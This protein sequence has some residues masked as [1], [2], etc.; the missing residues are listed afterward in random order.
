MIAI[1][2]NSLAGGGAEKVVLTLVKEIGASGID[3]QLILVEREQF[4][5]LPPNVK[6]HYLTDYENIGGS[7]NKFLSVFS[8]ARLLKKL[9]ETHQIEVVQSHLIRSNYINVL[10]QVMGSPHKS[11]IVNHMLVSF[12]KKRGLLGKGNLRLY[13]MLYHKADMI[14]SISKVMK[15]DLDEFFALPNTHPHQVIYNPHDIDTINKLAQ[16]TPEE[17]TFDPNKKYIISVGRL[18]ARKRVDVL[19]QAFAELRHE[20]PE[21][22]LLILGNGSE[23]ASYQSSAETLGVASS[24][25][26]MGHIQNPFAYLSRSDVF[27]L[28]SEDEGL[29]NI[30]IE[31][32]I[33]G[34]AVISSDCVS[35]PRE[36]L[37]PNSDINIRLTDQ[38]EYASYGI[39]FPVNN[40]ILLKEAL[41]QLLTNRDMRN[42]YIQQG[43]KRAEDFKAPKI[44]QAYLQSFN[45]IE[46]TTLDSLI[47]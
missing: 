10:A 16:S 43:F 41:Y 27:V 7:I 18:V 3:V 40:Q 42:R 28:A 44:A 45:K 8:C 12:D 14:V 25:H 6:V 37:S 23:L 38:L 46:S 32:L 4:Y 5:T 35:G 39:L 11:Q 30:I 1:L 15:K 34:T 26:F 17:F 36:I 33:C 47:H 29:P 9:V 21:T 2:I 19:I 20:L 13:K 22:E 31:S 24:V